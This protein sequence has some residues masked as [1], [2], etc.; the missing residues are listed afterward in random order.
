MTKNTFHLI[1][2][3]C[4]KNTVDS[5]SMAQL[6]ESS[7]FRLVDSPARARIVIV[8]TCGFIGPAREESIRSLRELAAGKGRKQTL[9]A[10]GKAFA[11]PPESV[12]TA[13]AE[14][15]AWQ[16]TLSAIAS[17]AAVQ[18]VTVMPDIPG[19]VK[20][21]A[22]EPGAYKKGTGLYAPYIFETRDG[23]RIKDLGTGGYRAIAARQ[24]DLILT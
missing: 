3:G 12:S 14:K 7:G 5:E 8:N 9:I 1:S 20:E 21:I 2:L 22:F 6:M 16:G 18:G 13:V 11:P 10:A 17:V 15:Q 23:I 19:T 24:P 4:A